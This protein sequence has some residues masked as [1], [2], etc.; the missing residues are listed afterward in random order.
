ML[1]LSLRRTLLAAPFC[2][3]AAGRAMGWDGLRDICGCRL[4]A[5]HALLPVVCCPALHACIAVRACVRLLCL[6]LRGGCL[7]LLLLALLWVMDV[8]VGVGLV[9]VEVR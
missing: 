9:Q 2:S 6:V 8:Y 1:S 7:L 3:A 5:A 4:R